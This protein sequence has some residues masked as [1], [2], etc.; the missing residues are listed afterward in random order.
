MT[1]FSAHFDIKFA[2]LNS[3]ELIASLYQSID[4]V[5]PSLWLYCPKWHLKGVY[6]CIVVYWTLARQVSGDLMCPECFLNYQILVF[7]HLELNKYLT[8]SVLLEAFICFHEFLTAIIVC[9]LGYAQ[10]YVIFY[11]SSPIPL[12]IVIMVMVIVI[13]IIVIMIIAIDEL[14]R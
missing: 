9:C 14:S 4:R 12:H 11:F 7:F 1:I 6:E 10:F 13:M 5:A 2:C 8:N 3:S